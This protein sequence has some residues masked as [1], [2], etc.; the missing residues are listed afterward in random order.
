MNLEDQRRAGSTALQE[1]RNHESS[2][3]DLDEVRRQAREDWRKKY[4][5]RQ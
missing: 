2:V 4:S 5:D 3:S 1:S